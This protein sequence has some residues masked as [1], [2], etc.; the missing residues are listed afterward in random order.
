MKGLEDLKA[1]KEI[2]ILGDR[3]TLT[4]LFV[5]VTGCLS[6]FRTVTIPM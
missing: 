4:N 6:W 2:K 5:I 1:K 3:L